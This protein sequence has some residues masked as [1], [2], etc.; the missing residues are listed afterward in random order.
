[1]RG[2]NWMRWP[3]A[4]EPAGVE[5]LRGIVAYEDNRLAEAEASFTRALEQDPSD[6]ESMQNARRDPL[7]DGQAGGCDSA[8]GEGAFRGPIANADPNYV[9]ALCYGRHEALRRCPSR[10]RGAVRLR[11]GFGAAWLVTARMLFARN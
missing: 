8:S 9:L 3:H 2:G 4:T 1:M 10:V 6:L 7:P 5:R 11:A